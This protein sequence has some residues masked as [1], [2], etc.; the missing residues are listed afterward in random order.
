MI[1]GRA[2]DSDGQ[3]VPGISIVLKSTKKG[4]VTDQNGAFSLKQ[5][6]K[7]PELSISMVG[8]IPVT[9][10]INKARQKVTM[11][12]DAQALNE[13]V[14]VGYG[15]KRKSD[16]TASVSTVNA[17]MAAA[18]AS[19][20][21]YETITIR[22]KSSLDDA[23][24]ETGATKPATPSIRRNFSE[25]AFFFPQLQTD[26]EGRILLKFTM[27][28]ALTRWRLLAFAHTKDMLVGTMEK[29]VVTQK[30]LMI[31]A[32]APRFLRRR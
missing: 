7:N 28:E 5:Q 6:R 10:T 20:M 29:E 3:P 4:A 17:R 32:N 19:E 12:P 25:T 8:F 14:V 2:L 22:G 31:T 18:P 16:V 21:L 24:A 26:K 13:V 1:T 11:R 23:K 15:A 27:P 9:V 30:E